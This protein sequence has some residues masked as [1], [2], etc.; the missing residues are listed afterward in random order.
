MLGICSASFDILIE[1]QNMFVLGDLQKRKEERALF[2]LN[3]FI[4]YT[5]FF[6]SN[7]RRIKMVNSEQPAHLSV[8]RSETTRMPIAECS[9]SIMIV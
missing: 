6:V 4:K 9:S 5:T 7:Q 2:P 1:T 8:E 3:V